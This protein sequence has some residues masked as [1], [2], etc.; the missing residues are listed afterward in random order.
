MAENDQLLIPNAAKADLKSFEILRVWVANKGQH[1]SL[2]VGV[3]NDPAAW[4]IMLADL[5][6]HIANAYNQD[7]ALDRQKTLRRIEAAFNAEM[8]EP[9]DDPTGR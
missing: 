7:A 3:W 8:V 6:K 2:R 9:T 5:A 4:G 1:I